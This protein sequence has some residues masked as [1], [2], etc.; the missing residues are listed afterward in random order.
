M[1]KCI[2]DIACEIIDRRKHADIY[3]VSEG[4]NSKKV[5]CACRCTLM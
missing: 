3:P 5:R 4:S 2:L 1:L